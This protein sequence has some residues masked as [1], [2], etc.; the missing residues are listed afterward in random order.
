MNKLSAIKKLAAYKRQVIRGLML[1]SFLIIFIVAAGKIGDVKK[2]LKNNASLLSVK[3]GNTFVG[4]AETTDF[5][6]FNFTITTKDA[7]VNDYSDEAVTET[8]Y[9]LIGKSI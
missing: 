9:Y 2:Q 7:I 6:K 8:I 4:I 1:A 5:S 3:S